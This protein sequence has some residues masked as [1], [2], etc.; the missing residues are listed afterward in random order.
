MSQA[1]G[2][3]ILWGLGSVSE[4]AETHSSTAQVHPASESRS[5]AGWL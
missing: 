2:Q 4:C 5:W 1:W 3:L